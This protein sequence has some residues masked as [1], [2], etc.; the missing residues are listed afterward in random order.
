M[1][2]LKRGGGDIASVWFI[3]G[4]L[5]LLTL[6]FGALGL[7]LIASGESAGLVMS[8]FALPFAALTYYVYREAHARASTRII[9][10]GETLELRL[11]AQRSYAPQEKTET[12]LPLSSVRAIEK[13]AEAFRALGTTVVQSAYALVLTNGRRIVL[14][15]D[16]R[17]TQPFY[18]NAAI[19]IAAHTRLAI[20]DRGLVDGDAGFLLIS[21]QRTPG[22]EAAPVAAGALQKRIRD[23][24]VTWRVVS[25][26]VGAGLAIG[27]VARAFSG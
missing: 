4:L 5:G 26:L 10:N 18:E 17:F 8:V 13:R 7:E 3:V 19:A 27:A 2:Q 22:W 25:I 14:G 15:A 23:E 12:T 16:R 21:G 24:A 9:I 20:Q 1:I 11:P 6:M